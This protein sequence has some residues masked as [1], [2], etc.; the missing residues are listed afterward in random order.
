MRLF[1]PSDSMPAAAAFTLFHSY[2][3]FLVEIIIK[4]R[5]TLFQVK[6]VRATSFSTR[7]PEYDIPVVDKAVDAAWKVEQPRRM[8]TQSKG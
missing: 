2:V 1:R 5:F 4:C 8:P 6:T 7:I 3:L